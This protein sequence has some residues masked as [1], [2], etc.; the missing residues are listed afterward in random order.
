MQ[1]DA[2]DNYAVKLTS[3]ANAEKPRVMRY[4][5]NVRWKYSFKVI[6]VIGVDDNRKLMYDLLLVTVT[7]CRVISQIMVR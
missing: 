4:S 7:A 3:S 5:G 1:H 2:V 6:N